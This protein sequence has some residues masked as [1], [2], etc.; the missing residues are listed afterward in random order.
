MSSKFA[1]EGLSESVAYE[2]EQFGIKVILIEPGVIKTNFDSNLK[3]GKGVATTTNTTTNGRDSPYADI[4]K[5]RMRDSTR[6]ENGLPPIEVSKVI[7]RAITST[8]KN[9]PPESRYLVGEDAFKLM[10]IR[11]SKSDKEFRRL[12]MEGVLK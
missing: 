4:T 7:L 12:V 8:S 11:K 9:I 1:L 5:K 6:F 10:E 3:I 2:V